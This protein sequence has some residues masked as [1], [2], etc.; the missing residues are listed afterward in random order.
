MVTIDD[1]ELLRLI[2]KG[3]HGK[4]ILC[5]K[6]NSPGQL[7]A[8]KIIKKQHIIENN[9]LE[10][11]KAE[12][13]ILSSINHVFLVSLKYAFQTNQKLY[14]VMEFMKGGELF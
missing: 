12:N 11:T 8:M 9:Q 1:F 13:L 2:G 3:A 14:F 4:V 10:H 7:Y 5:E 6:K